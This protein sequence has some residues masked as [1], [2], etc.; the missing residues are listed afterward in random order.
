MLCLDALEMLD[1]SCQERVVL[2]IRRHP[3]LHCVDEDEANEQPG[4]D[5]E[6]ANA[7]PR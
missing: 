7:A 1:G 5:D 3:P 6:A 4:G 2:E